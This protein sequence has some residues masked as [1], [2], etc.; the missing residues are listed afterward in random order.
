LQQGIIG[1]MMNNKATQQGR[2]TRQS[3]NNKA[4]SK[5]KE[6]TLTQ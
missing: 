4:K 5:K 3:K 6:K 1:M 2:A